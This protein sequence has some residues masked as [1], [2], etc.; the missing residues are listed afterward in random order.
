[1]GLVG[2]SEASLSNSRK[3]Q[4]AKSQEYDQIKTITRFASF[5]L[6]A[7]RLRQ[8]AAI[9]LYHFRR[10][11]RWRCGQGCREGVMKGSV[12]TIDTDAGLE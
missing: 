9:W 10:A 11:I 4:F 1:M 3:K 6:A 2:S 8:Q 5:A 7:H 12:L